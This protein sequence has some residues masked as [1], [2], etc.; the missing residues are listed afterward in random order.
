MSC[1]RRIQCASRGPT[2]AFRKMPIASR[3]HT[4]DVRAQPREP[5]GWAAGLGIGPSARYERKT[6]VCVYDGY[7]LASEQSTLIRAPAPLGAM[8]SRVAPSQTMSRVPLDELTR[9]PQLVLA[10]PASGH[11]VQGADPA[12]E[13][14]HG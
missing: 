8:W 14:I 4:S 13:R 2:M 6:F 10:V 12:F 3:D 5:A 1:I 9:P 11:H 7:L